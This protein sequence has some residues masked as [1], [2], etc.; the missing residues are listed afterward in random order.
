MATDS[1]QLRH[2]NVNEDGEPYDVHDTFK[3]ALAKLQQFPNDT[4]VTVL[5]G[6]D[7]HAGLV[8]LCEESIE[9]GLSR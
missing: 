4:I 1:A 8:K 6:S 7:S 3:A 2:F 5:S 9:R